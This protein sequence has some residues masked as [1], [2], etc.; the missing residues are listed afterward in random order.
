MK[1]LQPFE[2]ARL[3]VLPRYVKLGTI[4][5]WFLS[6]NAGEAVLE[7]GVPAICTYAKGRRRVFGILLGLAKPSCF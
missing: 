3:N 2:K 4:Q 5:F 6:A 1:K 7:K